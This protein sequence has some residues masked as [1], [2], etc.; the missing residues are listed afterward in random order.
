MSANALNKYI[1]VLWKQLLHHEREEFDTLARKDKER[2]LL[3]LMIY[4][5]Q[6]TDR[7]APRYADEI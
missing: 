6:V 5:E 4:N 1:G 3:E 7:I 2:Y